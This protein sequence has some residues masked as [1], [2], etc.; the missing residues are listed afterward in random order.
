M[1]KAASNTTEGNNHNK[2][3]K[4]YKLVSGWLQ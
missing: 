1:E 4:S 3:S 2:D